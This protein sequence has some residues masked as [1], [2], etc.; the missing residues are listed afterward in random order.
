MA[1]NNNNS[2]TGVGF[3]G[4]LAVAFIVLRL[5]H[6]INWSWWWVLAPIWAPIVTA[7]LFLGII[8]IT[9]TIKSLKRK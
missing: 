9:E 6:V 1:N 7:I 8:F 2:S 4:L 3:C 5:C